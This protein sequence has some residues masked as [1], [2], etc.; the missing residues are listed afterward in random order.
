MT[1]RAVSVTLR[2]ET[3]P[4]MK[5]SDPG[6]SMKF[7]FSPFHSTLNTVEKTE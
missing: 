5:S 1:I 7:N 6:Q 3:A 4:P 2:A